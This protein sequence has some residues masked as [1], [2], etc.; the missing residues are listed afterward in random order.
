MF[1]N[2]KWKIGAAIIALCITICAVYMAVDTS[3]NRAASEQV[4]S[5]LVN[6]KGYTPSDIAEIKT[7][8]GKAS[9]MLTT[10]IFRDEPNAMYFYTVRDHK[11]LQI[12]Y[13][14]AIYDYKQIYKHAEHPI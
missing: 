7:T 13:V 10:I 6:E 8:N 11:V 12:N 9:P 4:M 14:P 3:R 5:Y 1:I 2:K